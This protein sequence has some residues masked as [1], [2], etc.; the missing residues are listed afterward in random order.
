MDRKFNSGFLFK[1]C[2]GTISWAHR[3]QSYVS[4]STAEAEFGALS[5]AS[6]ETIW[7]QRLLHDLEES[8]PTGQLNE[9]YQF[10]LKMQQS[11]KFSSRTKHI[12]TR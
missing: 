5:E 11:E 6:Q 3:K 4:M 1:F 2:G 12:D 10:C 8:V 9:D 7:L